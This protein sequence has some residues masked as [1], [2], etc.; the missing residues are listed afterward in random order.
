MAGFSGSGEGGRTISCLIKD[1][2]E[3]PVLLFSVQY[4]R[5][6]LQNRIGNLGSWTLSWFSA[7]IELI[8][9]LVAGRVYF[10]FCVRIML[11]TH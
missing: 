8:F 7:G 9:F 4:L 6:T 1:L 2:F 5:P 3:A 11:I 10:G